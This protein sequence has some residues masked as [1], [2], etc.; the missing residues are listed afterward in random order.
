MINRGTIFSTLSIRHTNFVSWNIF[1][2]AISSCW[3]LYNKSLKV[4]GLKKSGFLAL[5]ILCTDWAQMSGSSAGFA[6]NLACS[7]SQLVVRSA[8][9]LAS[10]LPWAGHLRWFLHP[11]RWCF[12]SPPYGIPS[13][14]AFPLQQRSQ[15]ITWWLASKSTKIKAAHLS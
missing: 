15:T 3:L 1:E 9:A 6:W 7:C 10:S 12:S 8:N 14:G 13:P 11:Q 5:I 2:W 4:T